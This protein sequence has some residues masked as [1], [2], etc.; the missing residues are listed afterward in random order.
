MQKTKSLKGD[1]EIIL[2]KTVAK[3][4]PQT[5][6]SHMAEE[7]VLGYP[8]MNHERLLSRARKGDYV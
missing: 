6:S 3:L 2:N 8:V 4:Y 1:G 5:N 7:E